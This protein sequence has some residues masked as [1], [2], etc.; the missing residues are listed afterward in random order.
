MNRLIEYQSVTTL[1][2]E[3]V[4]HMN[5]VHGLNDSCTTSRAS[6]FYRHNCVCDVFASI[7]FKCLEAKH[8]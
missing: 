8:R 3:S 6:V 4:V 7:L 5:G 2:P 1:E